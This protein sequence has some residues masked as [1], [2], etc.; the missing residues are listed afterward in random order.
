MRHFFASRPVPA[1]P[2]GMRA[3][4]VTA[5]LVPRAGGTQGAAPG[6]RSAVAGTVD[7]AVVA[8]TADQRLGAASRAN[9]HACRRCVV[10]ARTADDTWTNAAVAAILPLH[11]GPA[12]CGARRRTKLPGLSA[13]PCLFFTKDKLLPRHRPQRH[14]EHHRQAK[15]HHLIEAPTL[16]QCLPQQRQF[17]RSPDLHGFRPPPTTVSLRSRSVARN[18]RRR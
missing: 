8:A 17:A 5:G 7:L 16:T 12:R 15:T 13:A 3:P 10:M 4:P 14:G 18:S 6:T 11:T 2:L 9:K 1:C